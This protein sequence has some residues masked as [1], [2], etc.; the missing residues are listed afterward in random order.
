MA[1]LTQSTEA[2]VSCS[3]NSQDC[4]RFSKDLDSLACYLGKANFE[5]REACPLLCCVSND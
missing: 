5:Y 2:A 3:Q 1:M 4:I